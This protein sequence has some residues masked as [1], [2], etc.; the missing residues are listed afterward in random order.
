MP[1]VT[2]ILTSYNHERFLPNSIDSILS[3]TYSDF[4]LWIID[5]ASTDG[6]WQIIEEYKSRDSRVHSIR[7]ERNLYDTNCSIPLH[8]A[9]F[10]GIYYAI[11]HSDDMWA[12]EKLEKQVAYL[13]ETPK[14][15]ACFTWAP[16]IGDNGKP[17]KNP[18][19]Y[20]A[21]V[22]QQP[23][24]TRYEWLRFFFFEGCPLCH[25]S[26]LIRKE[27]YQKYD[28]FTTALHSLPDFCKWIRLCEHAEIHIIEEPLTLFRIHDDE[29]N[30]S[31]DGLENRFRSATENYLILEEF[32]KIS[33]PDEIENIFPETAEYK[34]NGEM[35]IPYAIAMMDLSSSSRQHQ[36]HG[37]ETLYHLLENPVTK[38]S[39]SRLYGYDENQYNRDKQRFDV[40]N[41]VSE[42]QYMTC[43]LFADLGDGF[44]SEISQ[45]CKPYRSSNGR[46][47]A[48]WDLTKLCNGKKPVALRI[49]PDE[50]HFWRLHPLSLK[51]DESNGR[52]VPQNALSHD[53]EW[54]TFMTCDP[55]YII[56][57]ETPATGN[58]K[59]SCSA[60]AIDPYTVE[61]YWNNE[62]I[63]SRKNGLI[64]NL[65]RKCKQKLQHRPQTT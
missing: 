40:F 21:R 54:D 29:S 51:L 11:A 52:L 24:R 57:G 25:P 8:M 32:D 37:L 26:L 30:T 23:N 53:E 34:K 6:S 41:S 38:D 42:S 59:F 10:S 48:Q 46:F 55:I 17:Y 14:V 27:T 35:V 31:G 12:P 4:E 5:D 18:D 62:I 58:V 28:L 63:S 49:D 36:L 61:T 3:Q 65:I 39:I 60:K 45:I 20:L 44:T 43:T 1:K 2:V 50:G 64:N 33:S 47:E 13:D 7:H 56:E 19:H 15:A 9:N 16:A 22:F